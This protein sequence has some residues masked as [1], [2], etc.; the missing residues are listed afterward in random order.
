MSA[1]RSLLRRAKMLP[2]GELEGLPT[3]SNVARPRKGSI[4]MLRR[5]KSVGAESDWRLSEEM[6]G[7]NLFW[8]L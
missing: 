6:S 1:R 2:V 7:Q 3:V 8:K 5:K 4:D